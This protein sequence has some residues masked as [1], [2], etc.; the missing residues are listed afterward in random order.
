MWL[1]VEN[2]LAFDH[3]ARVLQAGVVSKSVQ[4]VILSSSF[5]VPWLG[6]VLLTPMIQKYGVYTCVQNI[7]RLRLVLALVR[8][9]TRSVNSVR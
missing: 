9:I 8:C 5:I 6:M 7:F 3:N 1:R 4:G 2:L